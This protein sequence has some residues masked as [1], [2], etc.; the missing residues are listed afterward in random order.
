MTRNSFDNFLENEIV[1]QETID[2][3]EENFEQPENDLSY[4]K[5][6]DFHEEKELVD[7]HH[8]PSF[9]SFP[10]FSEQREEIV[11]FLNSLPINEIVHYV[12]VT[13]SGALI[14]AA[15]IVL[16]FAYFE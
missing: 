1:G 12:R 3:G 10:S 6:N 16:Y 9:F 11:D 2:E 8:I 13:L 5:E 15:I 7:Q 14:L 4:Q